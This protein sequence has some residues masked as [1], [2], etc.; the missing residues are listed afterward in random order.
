MQNTT[1]DS[2]TTHKTSAWRKEKAD[3]KVFGIG[4]NRQA[5]AGQA[6]LD[7]RANSKKT[8]ESVFCLLCCISQD[9]QDRPGRA[10]GEQDWPDS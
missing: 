3:S 5:R 7:N 1:T 8:V 4:M 10:G 2:K 9:W 6:V